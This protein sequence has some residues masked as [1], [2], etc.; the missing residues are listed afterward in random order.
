MRN[1][2]HVLVEKP[3]T[4]CYRHSVELVAQARS[5]RRVLMENMTAPRH[6]QH[7][8][9]ERLVADGEIGAL[10]SFSAA[11]GI[12][13]LPA[14]DIRYRPEL[15]G[16]ALLDLGIYAVRAAVRFAGPGLSVEGAVLRTDPETGVDTSGAALLRTPDGVDVH[17]AYG[18]EHAYTSGYTLWGSAG[19]ITATRTAAPPPELRPELTVERKGETRTIA[20][21][22]DDQDSA[23][24]AAFAAQVRG[25]EST[26]GHQAP[27]LRTARLLDAIRAAARP[28]AERPERRPR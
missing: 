4:C 18:F 9:V 7:K 10:R 12:P 26:A 13:P 5:S 17:L 6:A 28:T 24:L 21:P 25:Q 19:R 15:G 22:A 1:G 27:T 14:E 20:A 11:Y 3:L 16:G 23:T 2:K 8:V